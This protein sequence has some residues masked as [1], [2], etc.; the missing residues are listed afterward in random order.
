MVKV[1]VIVSKEDNIIDQKFDDI[2]IID[3]LDDAKGDYVY[4]KNPQDNFDSDLL[5]E[6]FKKSVENDLDFM[7][8][9]TYGIEPDRDIY[10]LDDLSNDIFKTDLKLSSK[11]IK[12]SLISKDFN[13]D[14]LKLFNFDVLLSGSKFSFTDYLSYTPREMNETVD[15]TIDEWNSI[16]KKFMDYGVFKNFKQGLYNHKLEVLLKSYENTPD[17]LK[18][19]AYESLK[20]D[21]K[22]MVYH[23]RFADFSI[24][25]TVLNKLFYDNAVFSKNFEEYCE[26]MQYYYIKVDVFQI[27]GELEGI[28]QENKR[29]RWETRKL[30][31]IN[32]DIINSKS[33][34][35]TKP[36]RDAKRLM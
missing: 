32:K 24:F 6:S 28:E 25:T 3:Q 22:K 10:K 33:W 5:I 23:R 13:H 9:N 35:L 14:D 12:R 26:L 36:L 15:D 30:N 20:D 19:E 34:S 16:V 17:D 18:L 2:E 7:V 21:F 29:I 8:L 11:L 27:K 31:K 4:F 1:S